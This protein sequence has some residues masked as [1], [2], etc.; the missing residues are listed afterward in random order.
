MHT[1]IA[2]L[3]LSLASGCG[4]D[5]PAA[6]TPSHAT[7]TNDA[8]D[9]TSPEDVIAPDT[10]DIATADIAVVEP[11]VSELTDAGADAAP[12]VPPPNP[13][14]SSPG[15]PF[16]T[17]EGAA[18][19]NSVALPLS[20]EAF[21]CVAGEPQVTACSPD[22][23]C[24]AG[25]CLPAGDP[26]VDWTSDSPLMIWSV[27]PIAEGCCRDFSGD[28]VPDNAFGRGWELSAY[29]EG[30]GPEGLLETLE[31][32]IRS[33]EFI[34]TFVVSRTKGRAPETAVV[35]P[36]KGE[37]NPK[38]N[39]WP[40]ASVKSGAAEPRAFVAGTAVPVARFEGTV[41]AFPDTLGAVNTAQTPILDL[42]FGVGTTVALT[43]RLRGVE[44]ELERT[45]PVGGAEVTGVARLSGLI[46][47][48]D[49][50][51]SF[52]ELVE[53]DCACLGLPG[54]LLGRSA[55]DPLRLVTVNTT[56]D[57]NACDYAADNC[58]ALV[59]L[60]A[61]GFLEKFIADVDSDDDGLADS[62]SVGIRFKVAPTGGV[63]PP[64][65]E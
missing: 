15:G 29:N 21:L 23:I 35:F 48:D 59:L 9:V 60:A 25:Y 28:G 7:Q 50:A 40:P 54:P 18:T 45:G 57:E 39:P 52:N 32:G 36:L 24:G 63:L 6:S 34:P 53:A 44:F 11:D 8:F 47:L 13:C 10:V 30:S 64:A 27:D 55:S 22:Q 51:A 65:V 62:L 1:R 58:V 26:D 19:A 41:V 49:L 3:A 31:K 38:D 20:D 12:D 61:S 5:A 16:C 14:Q 46:H 37:V 42:R 17:P 33:G 43:L 56:L 4:D 2:L